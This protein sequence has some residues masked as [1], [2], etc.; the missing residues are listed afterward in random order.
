MR[1]LIFS[2]CFLILSISTL[3]Q[4]K[5]HGTVTDPDH[6]GVPAASIYIPDLKRGTVTDLNGN[7]I[8]DNLPKGKIL[9]EFKCLGFSSVITTIQIDGDVE[10]SIEMNNT[11]TELSE[12]IV[13]GI[14]HSTELKNNPIPIATVNSKALTENSSTNL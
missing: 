3:A 11:I 14:S 4:N 9:V 1:S 7:Y 6:A 5:L 13:T 12:V 2:F 10:F 8:F